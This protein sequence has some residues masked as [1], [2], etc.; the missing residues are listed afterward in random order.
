MLAGIDPKLAIAGAFGLAFAALVLVD[1]TVGLCLFTFLSFLELLLVSEDR[2]FS[3]LKVSGFLLLLSWVVH[4]HHARRRRTR[5][6]SPPIRSSP[7]SCSL[8]LGLAVLS[9]LWAED[10]GRAINTSWRYF[11]NMLL[12]LIVYTAIRDR[13]HVIG[14]R[15]SWLAGATFAT[16]PAIM[17]PPEPRPT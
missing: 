15:W 3:F 17:N 4:G 6:S 8:F 12:F 7:T 5:T 13:T 14:S 10:P 16:V 2:S 11:Q 1:L 9:S